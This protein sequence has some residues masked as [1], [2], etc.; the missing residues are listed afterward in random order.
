MSL[1]AEIRRANQNVFEIETKLRALIT[2]NGDVTFNLIDPVTGESTP[3]T[4]PSFPKMKS[5]FEL[6]RSA[7]QGNFKK[8]DRLTI[9][10]DITNG[11][12]ANDGIT[13]PVATLDRALEIAPRVSKYDVVEI[14]IAPGTYELNNVLRITQGYLMLKGT[15]AASTDVVINVNVDDTTVNDGVV[16]ALKSIVSL[17]N[18]NPVYSGTKNLLYSKYGGLIYVNNCKVDAPNSNIVATAHTGGFC[19]VGAGSTINGSSAGEGVH[20]ANNSSGFLDG[21][22][23]AS[24]NIGLSVTLGSSV[25]RTNVTYTNCTTN[26]NV[27]TTSAIKP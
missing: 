19:Y 8:L 17:W 11:N 12:D 15:G 26:E 25:Y 20:I 4:H 10:L 6:W 24:C 3:I 16:E 14:S 2:E 23:I 22:E 7:L 9:L 18:L 21:A 5:E 13:A 1:E 27:D